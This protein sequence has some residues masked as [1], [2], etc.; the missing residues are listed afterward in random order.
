MWGESMKLF[1]A[2]IKKRALSLMF[3]IISF[4]LAASALSCEPMVTIHIE[5]QTSETLQ[6]YYQDELFLGTA[7]PGGEVKWKYDAIYPTYNISGRD[8]A[9]NVVY[10][11]NFTREDL[12]GKKT[13]RVV[14]PPGV[15]ARTDNR[16]GK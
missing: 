14:I 16:S 9:G 5:N 12:S 10:S 6:I 4:S 1:G 11:A 2:K 13:Y 7:E 8:I 3:L 15:R